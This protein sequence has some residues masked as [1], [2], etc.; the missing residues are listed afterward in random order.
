M[1]SSI[2]MKKGLI[3]FAT[4]LFSITLFFQA[5]AQ[6]E[7]ENF[8]EDNF[9]ND[10]YDYRSQS[11]Y[12]ELMPGDSTKVSVVLY[13]NQ[14]Y[15]LFV[16]SD[17]E[18]G[19]VT[20]KIVRPEMKTKR[21]IKSIKRDTL[22]VYKANETGDYVTDD[23]GNLIIIDK[24]VNI[25]TTW[26]TERISVD[27]IAYNNKKNTDKPYLELVPKKSERY[28]VRITVPGNDPNLYGCVNVY[29]GRSP[30]ISRKFAK[31]GKKETGKTY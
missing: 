20:W 17:P 27:K 5:N 10:D 8:C 16:C 12:A 2:N 7:S 11:S 21:T 3:T 23:N 15:R 25:D 26:N 14:K 30:L 31:K 18:L 9:D 1:K 19:D 28:I 29:V 6:C 22:K 13:G 24:K 4:A